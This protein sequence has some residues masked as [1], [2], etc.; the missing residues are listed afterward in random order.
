[1]SD[2]R[3]TPANSRI[4]HVSRAGRS[5]LPLTEGR[6]ARVT[7]PVLDLFCHP[8]PG[9]RLDRQLIRGQ[10]FVILDEAAGQSFGF[11]PDPEGRVL[12]AGHVATK[13]LAPDPAP[14]H[15][16]SHHIRAPRSLAFAAPDLKTPNPVALSGGS[17]LR[18]TGREGQFAELDCGRFIPHIHLCALDDPAPDPV[19]VAEG[20]LGTPYL[21]GGNSGFGIDCSGLIS[22]AWSAMGRSCP[23]DSDLQQDLPG[24]RLDADAAPQR[25]DLLFWRGHVALVMDARMMIHANAH[26]MAVAAE[27]I[28]TAIARIEAQG[29]GP[30][31]LHLRPSSPTS[32]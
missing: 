24:Q 17:V 22:A 12:Y 2:P 11:L 9:Q 6:R 16:P 8:G 23:M 4:A 10:P 25:G 1:M 15:P 13:G 7:A 26:H 19:T 21:W 3:L 18:V 27:P 20:Y 31:T 5:D 32:P 14:E 29:G 30:V 28:V